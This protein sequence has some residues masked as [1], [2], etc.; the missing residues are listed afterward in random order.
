M[1]HKYNDAYFVMRRRALESRTPSADLRTLPAAKPT[2]GCPLPTLLQPCGAPSLRPHCTQLGLRTPAPSGVVGSRGLD[3]LSSP[4]LRVSNPPHTQYPALALQ[5]VVHS[6]GRQV[7]ASTPQDDG[8]HVCRRQ[9]RPLGQSSLSRHSLYATHGFPRVGVGAGS[10]N[11]MR[12]PLMTVRALMMLPLLVGCPTRRTSWERHTPLRLVHPWEHSVGLQLPGL[13]PH[14]AGTHGRL[15]HTWRRPRNIMQS[16]LLLHVVY[17]AHPNPGAPKVGRGLTKE[18]KASGWA[19]EGAVGETRVVGVLVGVGVGVGVGF[20]AGAAVTAT[21]KAARTAIAVAAAA[22]PRERRRTMVDGMGGS[23]G[24]AW[25]MGV[26][27][28]RKEGESWREMAVKGRGRRSV[29][30]VA[31]KRSRA[32]GGPRVAVADGAGGEERVG[33]GSGGKRRYWNPQRPS[34]CRPTAE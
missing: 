27:G 10:G 18:G 19:K 7:L 30:G 1:E 2:V 5:S 25:A 32:N 13:T 33:V 23:G 6:I 20:A 21:A 9:R 4:P 29:L 16:V 34:V 24:K 14:R 12:T 31:A 3:A 17:G 28:L 8:V 15:S 26:S 22:A 11:D